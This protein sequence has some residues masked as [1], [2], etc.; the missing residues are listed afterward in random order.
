MAKGNITIEFKAKGEKALQVAILNLDVATKRLNNQTSIYDKNLKNL[1][2]TQKQANKFL[3]QQNKLSLFGIKNNR[4]LANSFATIRSKLLL[5]SFDMGLATVA[6]KKLTDAAV[7]QERVEKKLEHQL[8]RSSKS[9]L[10][11]ASGLQ[12]VTKFGDE[13]I[14]NVQGMLAAF[15]KDEEQIKLATQA[16][17]DLAEA[18]GMDLKTAGDLV[19]KTLGSSTNAL[20]RYGIEVTGSANSILRLESLTKNIST[21]FAGEATAAANTFG[22]EIAQMTNSMGDAGEAMGNYFQPILR[23][24]VGFLKDA[25]D[26]TKEF[27]NRLNESELQTI[28]R[29]FEEMGVSAEEIAGIK[30]F[31]LTD[32]LDKVNEK[33]EATGTGFKTVEEVREA[34]KNQDL[35][36]PAEAISKQIDKQAKQQLYYNSLLDAQKRIEEG[37]AKIGMFRGQKSVQLLNE[38]GE[39]TKKL[40]ILD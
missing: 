17:L 3:A 35:S 6:F 4:L 29:R 40:A 39:E 25:A 14:I 19:S 26:S 1:G 30:N 15:T 7:E 22:G 31:M 34:I 16:T 18:K 21:I 38:Q 8:G 24:V 9:L 5:Y 10:N 37:T 20:A 11:Y 27:F 23:R 13:A 2:F 32:E 28:V 12:A 36:T 33:L